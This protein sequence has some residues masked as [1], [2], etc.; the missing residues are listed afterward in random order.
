MIKSM[1]AF[2]A[3]TNAGDW[4]NVIWE[5]RAVNHRYLECSYRLPEQFRYIE[6]SLR[7]KLRKVIS[8]GKIDITLKFK[9]SENY[10][11]KLSLNQ[12]LADKLADLTNQ[13]SQKLTQEVMVAP[14]NL[15]NWPDVI[16]VEEA[17]FTDLNLQILDSF[18]KLLQY[19]IDARVRE[20]QQL[21][22]L[23]NERLINLRPLITEIEKL[24]PNIMKNQQQKLLQ[25]VKN[26]TADY[27]E[28][29][30][31]QEIAIMAQKA[32]ISEELDRLNT[33]INEVSHALKQ[34]D[35]VGRRLD[36]LMQE[37]NREANTLAA[38]ANDIN[39]S[40]LTVEIKVLIDQMRE[41]VQ[42]IE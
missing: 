22:E 15:L 17:D 32:D 37:L 19:F 18:T 1:T 13:I 9:P 2:A 34:K 29:R 24:S 28:N 38:K 35:A 6:V 39:I 23:I 33:H 30:L 12:P 27:D 14:S 25:K 7:E 36:F 8:R 4:G 21:A 26:L 10:C 5:M 41:Q 3:I 20:G 31:Q 16:L 11:P 40:R 42:N